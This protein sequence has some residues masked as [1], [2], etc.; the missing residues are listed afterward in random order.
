MKT[1][2]KKI[3]SFEAKTHLSGLIDEVKNGTE[4]VITNRGKP[5]ARLIPYRISEQSS[6]LNEVIDSFEEVRNSV[7]GR[8]DIK[9]YISEGRKY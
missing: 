3:G 2:I 6:T 5:V 4:Y 8:V 1:I 7:E 9:N